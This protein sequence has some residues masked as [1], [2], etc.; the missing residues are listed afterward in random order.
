MH[1]QR[2]EVINRA[3]GSASEVIIPMINTADVEARISQ[4]QEQYAKE[5]DANFEQERVLKAAVRLGNGSVFR[6]L[7][8]CDAIQKARVTH[9]SKSDSYYRHLF[10]KT[11]DGF[12]TSKG[13]FVRPNVAYKVALKSGQITSSSYARSLKSL[14]GIKSKACGLN[15]VA[16]NEC[17]TS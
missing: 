10:T 9:E 1:L 7:Y 2:A 13:R 15:D 8:R 12:V 3:K 4:L 16:F 11:T 14:W 17:R 6:A 5:A